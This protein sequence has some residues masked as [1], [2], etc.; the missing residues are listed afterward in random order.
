MDE[1]WPGNSGWPF[2]QDNDD[3]EEVEDGVSPLTTGK[4][5]VPACVECEV[6]QNEFDV[7]QVGNA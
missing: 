6:E 3:D 7:K 4:A 5:A 2:T 1:N